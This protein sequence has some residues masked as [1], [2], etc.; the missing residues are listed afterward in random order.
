MTDQPPDPVADVAGIAA[1]VEAL[2]R[3]VAALSQL[4][5]Q[6]ERLSR[7]VARLATAAATQ[8]AGEEG[9]AA[10]WLALDCDTDTAAALLSHLCEWVATVYLRYSD[11]GRGLPDCWMR[12]P[13]MV[14]ELLWLRGAWLHAYG[15]NARPTDVGDWHDRQRPGVTRRIRIYGGACSIELHEPGQERAT[16]APSVLFA[17][18]AERIA[19]W[20][21]TDRDQPGPAPTHEELWKARLNSNNHKT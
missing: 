4:P 13:D 1:E 11:A 5:S 17:A 9:G 8:E 20:W 19:Q 21:T 16:T 15:K 3:H 18:A 7:V 12:H 14:E 2:S 6:V 10:T